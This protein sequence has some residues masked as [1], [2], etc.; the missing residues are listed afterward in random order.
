MKILTLLAFALPSLAQAQ[1]GETL[2]KAVAEMERLDA[3]RSTLA[4]AFAQSGAPANQKSFGEVCKPVGQSMQQGAATNGWTARQL[5]TRFRNPANAPDPEAEAQLRRFQLDPL[6]RA[7]LLNTTMNGRP[8]VRYLRRITVES[9]CLRCHGNKATRPAFVVE[10]YQQDRAY[11][12]RVGDLR[13]V[14][15]VFMPSTP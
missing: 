15:S 6:V 5:A 3:L 12:F 14:Y 8:G 10:N 11:G 2:G 4:A 1:S 7:V 9:S 13:G